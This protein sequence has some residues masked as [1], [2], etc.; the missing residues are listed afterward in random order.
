[1]RESHPTPTTYK[2]QDWTTSEDG[3]HAT[4]NTSLQWVILKTLP[5]HN[6][7]DA[8]LHNNM[9]EKLIFTCQRCNAHYDG[10]RPST[11]SELE[12][13]GQHFMPVYVGG[14]LVSS[15]TQGQRL[16]TDVYRC[17]CPVGKSRNIMLPFYDNQVGSSPKDTQDE[18]TLTYLHRCAK[19]FPGGPPIKSYAPD[20]NIEAVGPVAHRVIQDRVPIKISQV[21][22]VTSEPTRE[23]IP[24]LAEVFE[25][26][27]PKSAV[28]ETQKS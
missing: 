18:M 6:G 20:L 28:P 4:H 11:P 24:S 1:M 8:I 25:N 17:S 10:H 12:T 19:M 26:A 5:P 14:L 22:T 23:R 2:P 13:F 21:A 7:P 27:R 16:L 3:S 15:H 9:D